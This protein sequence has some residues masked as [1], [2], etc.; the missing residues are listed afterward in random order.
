MDLV[1]GAITLLFFVICLL[2]VGFLAKLGKTW[3]T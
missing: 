1:W 2:Y 3:K